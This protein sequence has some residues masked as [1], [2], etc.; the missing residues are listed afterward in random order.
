[1]EIVHK[2]EPFDR[3]ARFYV[4]DEDGSERFLM[5]L[6]DLALENLLRVGGAAKIEKLVLECADS[7][8]PA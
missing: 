7:K 2:R 8:T 1:M 4:A 3:F 5:T 6:S